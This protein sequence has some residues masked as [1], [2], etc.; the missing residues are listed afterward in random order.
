MSNYDARLVGAVTDKGSYREE[1]EDALWQ[2]DRTSPVHLGALYIVA[3]GVG[4]QEHG[5]IAARMAVAVLSDAFYRAREQGQDIPQ[6]LKIG[7]SEANQAVFDEAQLSGLRMGATVVTAVHHEGILY[8]AHVGDSR[9]YLISGQKLKPLTRD[10][11]LVQ[12][13]LDAGVITPAEAAQHQFRNL[14]TQVLGN[15]IDIEIHL[16]EPQPFAEADTLLLCTDGLSGVVAP[17]AIY[18]IV[19]NHS[20]TKAAEKLVKA[21]KEAGSQDNITAVVV[22]QAA[23]QPP[24]VPAPTA[25][26]KP[27]KERSVW[28][29]A[30]MIIFLLVVTALLW[31]WRGQDSAGDGVGGEATAV[32]LGLPAAD[33]ER[34]TP[35]RAVVIDEETAVPEATETPEAVETNQLEA[36]A[37]ETLIPEATATPEPTVTPANVGCVDP[38]IEIVYVWQVEDLTIETCAAAVAQLALNAGEFVTILETTPV[39]LPAPGFCADTDFIEVQ[40][41]DDAAIIG[42]VLDTQILRDEACP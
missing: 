24:L 38:N 31:W 12:K 29:W 15:R 18:D 20:A 14:V 16:A 40:A 33:G 28:L 22:T 32:P 41:A 25:A 9:A 10:D 23:N 39:A 34:L 30:A 7:I 8:I 35:E 42:W 3:D 5:G 37:T 13:Q 4:G 17:E 6:A 19:A 21:A 2:P 1:N 36:L 26:D 11:S 27:K